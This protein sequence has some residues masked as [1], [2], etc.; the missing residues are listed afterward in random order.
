[1]AR[2]LVAGPPWI[3]LHSWPFSFD[4][5]IFRDVVVNV[6]LYVPAGFTGHLAFRR[7]GKMW[8]SLAAPVLIC[9]CWSASIEMIQLYIPSRTCSAVDLATNIVGSM[10]GVFFALALEDVVAPRGARTASGKLRKR[11]DRVAL[12]LLACWAVWYLFPIFPVM[13]R[14][15]LRQKFDLFRHS[16]VLD[17]LPFFSALLIWLAGGTL[18][19]AG[20]LRPS[21]LYAAISVALI[22]AQIFILDRQPSPAELAGA[23]AGAACFAVF[24]PKRNVQGSIYWKI[25]AWAFLG[26]IVV[27]GF[28]PFQFLRTGVSFSWIPFG[29]FLN[30]EWQPGVQIVAEKSFLYGSAIWLVRASGLRLRTATAVV[31][32]TLLFIEIAQTHIPGHTA[33]ITDPLWAIF[34]GWAMLVGAPEQAPARPS[35]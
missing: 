15:L 19:R 33:E 20:G 25:L 35:R 11:P 28:A 16:P 12:S 21:R 7:F 2:D 17:L 30:M 6:A 34:A 1:V 31:A 24:W 4:R 26:M 29:G 32:A 27:R 8:L 18:L 3:L 9:A 23:V 10:I 5:F 13:G 22:P 14:M